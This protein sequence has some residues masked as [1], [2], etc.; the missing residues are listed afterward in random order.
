MTSKSTW[1]WAFAIPPGG[2]NALFIDKAVEGVFF[3]ESPGPYSI[4]F[5]PRTLSTSRRP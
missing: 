1:M 3:P 5:Q 2:M 4:L